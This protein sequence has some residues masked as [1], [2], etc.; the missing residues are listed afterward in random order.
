MSSNLS[1]SIVNSER[2]LEHA[3]RITTLEGLQI[4]CS[5]NVN[6]SLERIERKI[7]DLDKKVDKFQISEAFL[8]RH[9]EE[10]DRFKKGIISAF[11]SFGIAIFALIGN[12]IFGTK[13]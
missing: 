8:K 9:L 11:I 12:V 7:E 10:H 4:S 13:Q 3:E 2:V 1:D 6:I 5:K